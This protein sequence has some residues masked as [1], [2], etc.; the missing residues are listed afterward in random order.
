MTQVVLNIHRDTA[1]VA[2]SSAAGRERLGRA[3]AAAISAIPR[4]GR[5]IVYA[6]LDL[7]G[8]IAC[9]MSVR[10]VKGNCHVVD[11]DAP[12]TLIPGRGIVSEGLR[13]TPPVRHRRA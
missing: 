10:P 3:V 11:V 13:R 6:P 9:A 12:G 8:G 7:G 5:G 1:D 4:D 2:L